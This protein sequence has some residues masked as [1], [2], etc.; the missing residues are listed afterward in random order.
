MMNINGLPESDQ[1]LRR[2]TQRRSRLNDLP[3]RGKNKKTRLFIDNEY[4]S[5][6]YA[7][8]FYTS[9]LAVYAVLA[10]Y[11]NAERQTSFPA[12]PLIMREGGI[13]SRN[14]VIRDINLLELA[15][16]I[17]IDHSKGR[18]SNFYT[19]LDVSV[20]RPINSINL[21]TVKRSGGSQVSILDR[22]P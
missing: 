8:L 19:L 4:F 13:G 11:A 15:S 14:T 2:L 6:G 20:W 10:K 22:S 7:A 17:A 5:K 21:D 1:Y 18:R 16:I 3:I 9:T 12:I